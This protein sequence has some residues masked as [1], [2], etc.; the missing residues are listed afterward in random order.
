MIGITELLEDMKLPV[1]QKIF[2]LVAE[3]VKRAFQPCQS[4]GCSAFSLGFVCAR[5]SR[6]VC[7]RHGYVT[8][9]INPKPQIVCVSC[10]VDAHEEL[11]KK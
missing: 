9:S 5:C 8:A 1:E 2:G 11:W 4:P 7:Q 10:I 3:G 6:P